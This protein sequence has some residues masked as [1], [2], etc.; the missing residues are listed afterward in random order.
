MR[1]PG[2]FFAKER[3]GRGV[4]AAP[5]TK[6]KG[7]IMS[8][9]IVR[10]ITMPLDS[11]DHYDPTVERKDGSIGGGSGFLPDGDRI[12][13]SRSE[14]WRNQNDVNL[15]GLQ[16]LHCDTQRTVVRWGKDGKPVGPPRILGP[17]EP[18]PDCDAL[19]EAIPKSDWLP[20]FDD[21][22]RGPV[23]AQHV[24]VFADLA[25]TTRL[26]WPSPVSTIGSAIC[27][28]EL[29]TAVQRMRQF[30]GERL[31]VMV[32]LARCKFRTRYG[33]RQRPFLR[34]LYWA[35][36]GDKGLERVDTKALPGLQQVAEPSLQEELRDEVPWR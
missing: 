23:Q 27:V 10:K 13:F 19:N 31:D 12:A 36:P 18:F 30:R 34:I 7:E 28:R 24:L 14:D 3:V 5:K 4:T 33:D 26:V 11:I 29:T 22:L 35:R 15:T 6:R 25:S 8:S 20:G 21:E 32:E 16:V 9:E 17:G 2:V 1:R